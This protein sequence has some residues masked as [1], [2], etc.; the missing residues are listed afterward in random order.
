MTEPQY[1]LEGIVHTRTEQMEDFEG[2]LDV[3]FLLLSKNKIEIQDVSITA[4]LEQYLAYLEEMKRLDM[5]IASEFI[6]MASHLMLIKTK[7]LLSAAEQAE[8]ESE[9]DQLRAQLIERQRKEAIEAV[10]TAVA[11]LEPRNEIGRCVFTKEPE[12]LRRDNTY[13]YKHTTADLLRA[14][15]NIAERSQRRLPPPTVNFKGIVGK[16]P[17]PVTRKTGELLRH[18][19]LRGMEKLKNLFKGNRSRSEIVAT[20][21]SILDM[22][23]N[24]TVTLEDDVNGEN[25][26]VRLIN[27]PEKEVPEHGTN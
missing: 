17:Y 24:N 10:R 23:K 19:L 5:E 1:R 2:P 7:M 11:W 22:C 9:L 8:A 16:E 15:D 27:N 18:L 14:L 20:F 26:T 21:I 12:P 25:P 3:I 13:R 4:I 6:T